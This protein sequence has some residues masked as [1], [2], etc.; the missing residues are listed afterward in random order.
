VFS[1]CDDDV[2]HPR[3]LPVT[4]LRWRPEVS[5]GPWNAEIDKP[6]HHNILVSAYAKGLIKYWHTSSNQCLATLDT[7]GECLAHIDFDAALPLFATCSDRHLT[8]Y[9]E[10]SFQVSRRLQSSSDPREKLKLFQVKFHPTNP[11]LLFTG[12]WD[13]AV[14]MWDIRI[15][16]ETSV[17]ST[18]L[19]SRPAGVLSGPHVCGE[20]IDVDPFHDH[21]FAASW[22]RENNLQIFDLDTMRLI[23]E[24]DQFED[25]EKRNISMVQPYCGRYL[26]ANHILIA[27]SH[28]NSVKLVD[29]RDFS[30]AGSCA[31]LPGAAYCLDFRRHLRSKDDASNGGALKGGGAED[32]TIGV[33]TGDDIVFLKM[34]GGRG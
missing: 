19:G 25:Y 24:I 6:E 29:K 5:C 2:R 32:L 34:I 9:D 3:P 31:G 22:R 7:N 30:V 13:D 4:C 18:L 15:P 33:G 21:L 10:N 17:N 27:G 23:K 28:Q 20:S 8:I 16:A 11:H 12:G 14:D 26:G 1:L